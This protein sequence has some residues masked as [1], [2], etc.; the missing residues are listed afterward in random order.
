MDHWWVVKYWNTLCTGIINMGK[1]CLK[2]LRK[3]SLPP[4]QRSSQAHH[5]LKSDA[6]LEV[7]RGWMMAQTMTR[8][9]MAK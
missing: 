7:K 9:T 1:A 8:F 3:Q 5:L 2:A 6:F 4:S